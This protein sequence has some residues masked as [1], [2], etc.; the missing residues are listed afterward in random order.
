MIRL[1]CLLCSGRWWYQRLAGHLSSWPAATAYFR[2]LLPTPWSAVILLLMGSF[3]VSCIEQF[4]QSH[5][6]EGD[7]Q[8]LKRERQRHME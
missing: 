7:T 5:A 2:S 8:R 3:V 4:A 6:L 1:L